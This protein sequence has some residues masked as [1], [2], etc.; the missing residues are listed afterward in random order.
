MFMAHPV[1]CKSVDI[2]TLIGDVL[3]ACQ[4]LDANSGVGYDCPL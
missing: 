4:F 3:Y 2:F 1:I